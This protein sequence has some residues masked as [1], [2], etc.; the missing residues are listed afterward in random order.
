M[1]AK[2]PWQGG[3]ASQLI[4]LDNAF[5]NWFGLVRLLTW[6]A[7]GA[8]GA[9]LLCTTK[10]PAKG[11]G[12]CCVQLCLVSDW[13]NKGEW[14]SRCYYSMTIGKLSELWDGN[15]LYIRERFYFYTQKTLLIGLVIFIPGNSS[16]PSTD[17]NCNGNQCFYWKERNGLQSHH[18]PNDLCDCEYIIKSD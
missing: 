1:Y 10:W 4:I 13:T 9:S 14:C 18:Q 3:A 11:R 5:D 15:T 6:P 12:W 16:T 2:P 7:K 8:K 17:S